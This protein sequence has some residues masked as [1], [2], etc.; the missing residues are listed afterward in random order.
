[1]EVSLFFCFLSQFFS[2]VYFVAKE[3]YRTLLL[4]LLSP[5]FAQLLYFRTDNI[6]RRQ[7]FVEASSLEVPDYF[8]IVNID[9][10]YLFIH[11]WRKEFGQG[12]NN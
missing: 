4:K 9:K 3:V 6:P 11:L 2:S 12:T 7:L 10:A 5:R 1:M 8:I